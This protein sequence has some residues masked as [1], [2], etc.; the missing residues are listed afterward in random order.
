MVRI[1]RNEG[2]RLSLL[3]VLGVAWLFIALILTSTHGT[4]LARDQ[5]LENLKQTGKA[6]ASVAKQVSPAVVFIKI[7]K[8]V[9]AN[10]FMGPTLPFNDEFF[11]RFF[12]QPMPGPG[13]KQPQR[14]QQEQKR[15]IQGQGSGF[16]ISADGYILTNN[17]VVGSAD[18]VYVKLL[19]GREFTAK[20]VGTDPA[21]DV[22]VIKIDA[23]NLPVLPLGD[24]DK[25]DVGEWVLA[26]GNPFG[27]SHT[28]TAG[29]VSAKGRS[30]VG[31]ADYEDFIQT[32]AAI[33]PGNS[34]GP[35]IDLE[36]KVIGIN[37]AIYSQSGGSMG[38]GFAIPVNLAKGVYTQL[39][40]HGS[41]ERGYV[42]IM[43]QEI[44]PELA[45]SFKLKDTNGV[46]VA[47]VMPDT[48]GAKA[49][50]KQGDVIVKLNGEPVDEIG[51]FRNKIAMMKP[52]TTVKLGVIRDGAMKTFSVKIEK[53]PAKNAAAA[54]APQD[55]IGKAGITVTNLTKELAEKY[56]YQNE[57]GV[58]VTQVDPDSSA[59]RAGIAPGML[60]QEVNR[61][62]IKNTKDFEAAIGKKTDK[63][64]L[65]LVK[66]QQG[67]RYIALD[68]EK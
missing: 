46:L 52:G 48:P 29:I 40:E 15:M 50:L 20:T 16:I 13:D 38:I 43:I 21:T 30:H 67:S 24:S 22:A 3:H 32:D 65:M 33:N 37:T 49:G 62:E 60:I 45:K 1:T 9:K 44:T 6:F 54:A 51:P 14:P 10:P 59:A 34:G 58:V 42:G 35:L 11:R 66:N 27:L 28:L 63:P 17:H 61:K 4:A 8:S 18:K 7:E 31:I 41:V 2:Q 64:I 57:N 25:L 19:D 56:G 12:G 36:G 5:A 23:K 26:L 55:S 53:M 68:P 39:I 47:Q